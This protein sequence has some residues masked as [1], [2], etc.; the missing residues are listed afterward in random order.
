MIITSI[1]LENPWF[2][3]KKLIKMQQY[4]KLSV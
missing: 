3:I 2:Y 4:N 1:S